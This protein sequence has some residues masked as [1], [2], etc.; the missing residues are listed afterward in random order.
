MVHF[1]LNS[2][3]TVFI[4]RVINI[5]VWVATIIIPGLV[6]GIFFYAFNSILL[7]KYKNIKIADV[8]ILVILFWFKIYCE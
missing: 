6:Y 4:I 2:L 3:N 8:G 1:I 5:F 7:K